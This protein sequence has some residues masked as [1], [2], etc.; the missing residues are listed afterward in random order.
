MKKP[1]SLG[2]F[3]IAMKE[4]LVTSKK[5]FITPSKALVLTKTVLEKRISHAIT[6]EEM[7]NTPTKTHIVFILASTNQNEF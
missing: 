4:I 7:S 5:R 2:Q 6:N 3:F 1:G